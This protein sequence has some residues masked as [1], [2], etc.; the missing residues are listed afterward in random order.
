MYRDLHGNLDYKLSPTEHKHQSDIGYTM[1]TT[2]INYTNSATLLLATGDDVVQESLV[3]YPLRLAESVYNVNFV[4]S[5][6]AGS[7]VTADGL[8]FMRD[9]YTIDSLLACLLYKLH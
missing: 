5:F 2:N 7:V 9:P 8:N 6:M 4:L 1:Q 3:A